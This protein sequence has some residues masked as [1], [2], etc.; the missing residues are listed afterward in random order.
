MAE[1]LNLIVAVVFRC[2]GG[3]GRALCL[4]YLGSL[5]FDYAF[6]AVLQRVGV[7]VV[8]ETTAHQE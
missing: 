6:P 5:L 7:L 1:G 3:P 4:R 2:N 8:V